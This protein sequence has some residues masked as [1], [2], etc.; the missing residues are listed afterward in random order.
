MPRLNDDI[1]EMFEQPVK[2]PGSI[3]V[4]E[5]C[6]TNLKHRAKSQKVQSIVSNASNLW[7]P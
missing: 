6:E 1:F 2:S 5:K 7:V 4:Q 3:L